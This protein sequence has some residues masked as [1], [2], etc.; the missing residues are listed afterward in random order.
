[1]FDIL[2]IVAYDSAAAVQQLVHI[3]IVTYCILLLRCEHVTILTE[4]LIVTFTYA[5]TT[6][7]NLNCDIPA[8]AN[9]QSYMSIHVL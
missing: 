6:L 8:D 4:L 3:R 1:M 2:I 7:V 9:K 5:A